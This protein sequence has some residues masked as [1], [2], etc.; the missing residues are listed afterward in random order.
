MNGKKIVA[1]IKQISLDCHEKKPGDFF[2]HIK[3]Q[4]VY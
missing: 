3:R 1:N 2:D 4:M